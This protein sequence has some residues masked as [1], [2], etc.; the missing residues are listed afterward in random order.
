MS[1]EDGKKSGRGKH[2]N[3][4]KNLEKMRFKPGQSGN[5]KGRKPNIKYV[6]EALMELLAKNKGIKGITKEALADAL[7]MSLAKR[8]L[9]GDNALSILLDRTEGKVVQTFAG[10]IKSDVQFIIG[11]GYADNQPDIPADK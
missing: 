11:K 2:P 1:A 10:N 5:P 3:S 4:L 8:A 9:K 7:A 6:S